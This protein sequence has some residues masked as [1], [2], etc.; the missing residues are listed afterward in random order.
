MANIV[1]LSGRQFGRIL[2]LR[3]S[4]SNRFGASYWQCVCD[5][6][7]EKAVRGSSLTSGVIKSCGCLNSE[8]TA[9]RVTKHGGNGTAAHKSWRHMRDRCRNP[10]SKHFSYYGGRGVTICSRWDDFSAFWGDMGNPPAGYTLDRIDPNGDYEPSNCRW[11]SKETQGRN[12]RPRVNKSGH[13]GVYATPSGKWVSQIR[14]GNGQRAC[15]PAR[16]TIEEAIADRAELKRLH[17]GE[18]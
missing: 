13:T 11:A 6:G 3:Y 16:A 2:V 9:A 18:V 10:K 5:C 15:G 1:D 7:T 4:Y 8:L 17:W 12:Q 14:I